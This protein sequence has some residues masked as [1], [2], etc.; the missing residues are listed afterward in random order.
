MLWL[1]KSSAG[2]RTEFPKAGIALTLFNV[3]RVKSFSRHEAK[4]AFD[5]YSNPDYVRR[6]RY[7]IESG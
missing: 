2:P 3:G 4:G 6:I 1:R 5:R 7:T